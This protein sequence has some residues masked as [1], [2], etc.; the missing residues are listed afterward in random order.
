[1]RVSSGGNR[2]TLMKKLLSFIVIIFFCTSALGQQAWEYATIKQISSDGQF[3]V[4]INITEEKGGE[5]VTV[6][7]IGTNF[8]K[9]YAQAGEKL[10]EKTKDRAYS[11]IKN[12]LSCF[13]VLGEKHFE[14]TG[15]IASGEGNAQ[16]ILIFKRQRK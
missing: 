5:V 14:L 3:I 13:N 1:M 10:A 12:D 15:I 16:S 2:L 9:A 7:G 6:F 4:Q 8:P 11:K